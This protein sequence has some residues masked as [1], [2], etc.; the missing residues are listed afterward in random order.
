MSL[1]EIIDRERKRAFGFTDDRRC[2]FTYGDFR[3]LLMEIETAWK[4]EKAE[5]EAS[6]LAAG[7]IVEASRHKQG[8]A[9][10]GEDA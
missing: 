4:R 1:D 10:E 8:N 5:V 6:A 7:G 3:R 2:L 9:V